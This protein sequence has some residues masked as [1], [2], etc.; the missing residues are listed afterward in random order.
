[1]LNPEFPFNIVLQAKKFQSE[2]GGS[3]RI[4]YSH[5]KMG[6][7]LTQNITYKEYGGKSSP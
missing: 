5:F 3:L 1:M 7:M 6:A 2:F 4:N